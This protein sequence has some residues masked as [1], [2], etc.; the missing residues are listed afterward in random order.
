MASGSCLFARVPARPFLGL[1]LGGRLIKSPSLC[2]ADIVSI[3]HNGILKN[4][5]RNDRV[6]FGKG[7]FEGLLPSDPW[8]LRRAATPLVYVAVAP[9]QAIPKI[10]WD[11]E[12]S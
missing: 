1:R 9:L 10:S 6:S 12:R 4:G 8:P 5:S 11:R 2:W 3:P 7:P